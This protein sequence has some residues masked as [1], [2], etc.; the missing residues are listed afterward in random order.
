VKQII[1]LFVAAAFAGVSGLAVAQGT[2]LAAPVP[3]RTED[4]NPQ[5]KTDAPRP[6]AKVKKAKPTKKI[7]KA[8]AAS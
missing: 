8:K 4:A 6:E 1:T 7:K 3:A 2:A 5:A